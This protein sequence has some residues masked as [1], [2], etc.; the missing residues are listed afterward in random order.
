[1]EQRPNRQQAAA[2]GSETN[3]PTAPGRAPGDIVATAPA[4][5]PQRLAS[6]VCGRRGSS[7]LQLRGTLADAASMGSPLA[8]SRL[9]SCNVRIAS[10]ANASSYSSNKIARS[11]TLQTIGW[12]KIRKRPTPSTGD[13]Q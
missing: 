8:L 3:V 2:H 9:S 12:W 1:M 7:S 6:L 4:L 11:R 13:K 5:C 10:G